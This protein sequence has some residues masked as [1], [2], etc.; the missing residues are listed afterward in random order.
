MQDDTAAT[1]VALRVLMAILDRI[2]P[3]PTDVEELR[4]LAPECSDYP[5]DELACEV[6]E[7][8]L[9]KQTA[10]TAL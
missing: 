7:R 6:I 4:K 1:T 3:D 10:A 5:L 8:P 2:K 9:R